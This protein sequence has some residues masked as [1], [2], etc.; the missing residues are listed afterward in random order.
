[1][2]KLNTNAANV[3][4]V[5][6]AGG[7]F[8]A[9]GGVAQRLLQS[10]FNVNELRTQ[11]VLRKDEWIQF[12]EKVVEIATQRLVAVA[13]LMSRGLTYNVPNALGVTRVEWETQS[14]LGPA[15]VSMNGLSVG[16]NDR[17]EYTLNG[18][19]LPIIHKDFQ[20]NLRTLE[21]SRKLGQPLD[22]TGAQLAARIVSE[23]IEELLF[24]GS[25]IAGTGFTIP[26]YTTHSSR[27]TGST[28]ASWAT[29][30]GDQII[31]DILA[32][33]A[34][35]VGDHMYGP[36]MIYCSTAAMVN[37][38]DDYKAES[39]KTIL[40]RIREIP[41]IIDVKGT[42][43]LTSDEAL[44]VQMTSDVVDMVDGI[45]PMVVMWES[46]GGFL[47]NFKVLA[48]MVPRIKADRSGQSGIV[49]YT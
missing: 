31:N 22:T 3:D 23:K 4:V 40:Q 36:Y 48:I 42:E 37:L 17:P 35:A 14:D 29:S 49:H 45:Q 2:T 33:I 41:N 46:H 10:G 9:V 18:L 27:N 25:S 21:S 6:S 24:D 7:Q 1:M 34:Q 13:D 47:I 12:D 30:T 15:S 39:D 19:P 28:T 38:G 32:M 26:G 43:S 44:L 11:D 16:Q 8:S 5:H 20:I